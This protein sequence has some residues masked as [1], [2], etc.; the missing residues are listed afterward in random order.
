MPRKT[1]PFRE[2]ADRRL[3]AIFKRGPVRVSK[4]KRTKLVEEL[5]S[6]VTVYGRPN[7]RNVIK[8]IAEWEEHLENVRERFRSVAK[9]KELSFN[10]DKFIDSRLALL[11]PFQD[12][13]QRLVELCDE[14][15]SWVTEAWKQA[16]EN[17]KKIAKCCDGSMKAIGR[18]EERLSREMVSHVRSL[19]SSKLDKASRRAD[20]SSRESDLPAMNYSYACALACDDEMDEGK[21]MKLH[22]WFAE[23]LKSVRLSVIVFS[24]IREHLS[25]WEQALDPRKESR[26]ML[27]LLE[28][29][30]QNTGFVCI[31]ADEVEAKCQ[32]I[33]LA[34]SAGN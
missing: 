21:L 20:S 4:K 24:G 16:T 1:M 12:A 9:D 32:E 15:K 29:M 28:P 6:F 3:K 27:K 8:C 5:D 13:K 11:K 10:G 25:K 19:V 34:R 17:Y 31:V 14:E 23:Q 7:G 22:E 26:E 33:L 2:R 30:M 18:L